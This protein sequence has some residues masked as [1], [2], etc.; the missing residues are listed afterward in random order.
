MDVGFFEMFPE[1]YDDV[2]PV[3]RICPQLELSCRPSCWDTEPWE[4]RWEEKEGH[5]RAR[6]SRKLDWLT[7]HNLIAV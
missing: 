3:E 5:I 1:F 2:T 6:S 4:G 7:N